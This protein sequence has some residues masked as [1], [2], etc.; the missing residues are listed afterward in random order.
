MIPITPPTFSKIATIGAMTLF[1][2]VSNATMPVQGTISPVETYKR[3]YRYSVVEAQNMF[4]QMSLDGTP[5]AS[6]GQ[7]TET[8]LAVRFSGGFAADAKVK[9]KVELKL[10]RLGTYDSEP[11]FHLQHNSL[12]LLQTNTSAN[13]YVNNG[14]EGDAPTNTSYSTT[15]DDKNIRVIKHSDV[16][17]KTFYLECRTQPQGFPGQ[18]VA[19]LKFNVSFPTRRAWVHKNLDIFKLKT[20]DDDL[21]FTLSGSSAIGQEKPLATRS[22]IFQQ[23]QYRNQRDE[24]ETHIYKREERELVLSS[25]SGGE[26]IV[27][28]KIGLP[29]YLFDQAGGPITQRVFPRAEVK[30]T[31]EGESFKFKGPSGGIFDSGEWGWS[32]PH[33]IHGW[34]LCDHQ[35]SV[36]CPQSSIA[37]LSLS[38]QGSLGQTNTFRL[39]YKWGDG[40]S[41]TANYIESYGLQAQDV[42]Q[43]LQVLKVDWTNLQVIPFQGPNSWSDNM[44]G[45]GAR[46][47]ADLSIFEIGSKSLAV[48]GAVSGGIALGFA[49]ALSDLVIAYAG[50]QNNGPTQVSPKYPVM[51]E[52]P[53]DPAN[54]RHSVSNSWDV[55][56]ETSFFMA[57][58]TDYSNGVWQLRVPTTQIVQGVL[59]RQYDLSGYVQT[60]ESRVVNPQHWWQQPGRQIC[61]WRQK[62]TEGE[63]E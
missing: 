44:V 9:I 30:N 20:T 7:W 1:T 62:G 60:V 10:T 31:T 11:T 46:V 6:W 5:T 4:F 55:Q 43:V 24:I 8:P 48:A 63:G 57:S 33:W 28:A 39:D 25:T 12:V 32:L 54:H 22:S 17:E 26:S 41:A 47:G 23:W 61:F 35:Y 27:D 19:E 36:F 56:V 49:A 59:V 14:I 53:A 21:I 51:W 58:N 40:V 38:T 34:D 16:I 2:A 13:R 18:A 37:S 3:E 29:I 50:T 42:E 52:D 45:T 15:D